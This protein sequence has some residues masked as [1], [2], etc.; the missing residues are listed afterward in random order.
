VERVLRR[1]AGNALPGEELWCAASNLLDATR[2]G[3]FNQAMMELGATVCLPRN[4]QCLVCPLAVGCKT[5]GEHKTAPR[6]AMQSRA[7]GHA[8]A[9]RTGKDGGASKEEILLEQRAAEQT[10]MSGLWELPRLKDSVVPEGDLRMAVRHAI[11]QVNYDV[12]VRTVFEDDVEALT[13][14]G[15]TRRWVPVSEAA[16]MAL[17]GL[18]R[19]VLTRA[20]LISAATRNAHDAT[21]AAGDVAGRDIAGPNIAGENKVVF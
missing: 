11:M 2:P 15:G 5:L 17:T 13:V 7:V 21:A 6:A 20:Q 8:L 4:P 9:V 12:R 10:V 18:A 3:D 1:I 14:I 16:D 19:K